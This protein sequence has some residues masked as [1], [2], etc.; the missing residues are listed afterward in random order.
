MSGGKGVCAPQVFD[1]EEEDLS[2]G[3]PHHLMLRWIGVD[4]VRT[5]IMC[6]ASFW[7]GKKSVEICSGSIWLPCGM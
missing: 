7:Y 5:V 4:F 1:E 6:K 2:S 3:Y